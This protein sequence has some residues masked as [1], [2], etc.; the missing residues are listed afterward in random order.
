MK[1]LMELVEE[2]RTFDD[3]FL[4]HQEL[5]LKERWRDALELLKKFRRRL[6]VHMQEEEEILLP[7]YEERMGSPLGGSP[8]QFRLEHNKIRHLLNSFVDRER[9]LTWS[10]D[11]SVHDIIELI[12]EQRVFKHLMIHHDQRER[13]YLYPSLNTRTSLGE[14]LDMI[15]RIEQ[16]RMQYL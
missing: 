10:P 7:M 9:S 16:M 12:E 3:Q 15:Y 4:S 14:K 11:S 8:R 6:E 5:I 1:D 13:I 2:H